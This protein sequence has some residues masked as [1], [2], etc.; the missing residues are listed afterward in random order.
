MVAPEIVTRRRSVWHYG[1]CLLIGML[2]VWLAACSRTTEVPPTATT[3]P[4]AAVAPTA[5]LPPSPTTAPP[6]ET[7]S[8]TPTEA[9]TATAE[10][11]GEAQ[12]TT[13]G[14]LRLGSAVI[15][16]NFARGDQLFVN[17]QNLPPLE[18][19]KVYAGWLL[20]YEGVLS[21]PVGQIPVDAD[22]KAQL[23]FDAPGREN[24]LTNYDG[25][26]LSIEPEEIPEIPRG[27]V[28]A[29]GQVSLNSME[30][31]R[32]LLVSY[33]ETPGEVGLAVGLR[34][35]TGEVLRHTQYARDAARAEDLEG[36]KRHA[37]HVVL[38]I[39]GPNGP[40]YRDLDGDGQILD[41]GDSFG[42]LDAEGQLGY[43]RGVAEKAR[44]AGEA[45][46][47]TELTKIHS[48]HV[49]DAAENTKDWLTRVRDIALTIFADDDL[50]SAGGKVQ[51]MVAL[52]ERA[53]NGF[54]ANN[55][56]TIEPILGE[57]GAKIAYQHSQFLAEMP[58][59]IEDYE[60]PLPAVTVPDTP[61]PTPS[62]SPTATPPPPEEKAATVTMSNFGFGPETITVKAGTTVTFVNQDEAP[63]TATGDGKEFDTG[64]LKP[65]QSTEITF[66]QAG[67]F[68]Y[69]C[70]FHGGPGGQGMAGTIVVEP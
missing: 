53:L 25:F 33:P 15:R 35:Q 1:L 58:L 54:D 49:Q 29:W 7:P 21:L 65:G 12:Q 56:E 2:S 69:F 8:A 37:E 55:N 44:Q 38:L 31:I 41:P 34:E 48:Q 18:P 26:L 4:T 17:L 46:F 43:V 62:P 20:G 47:A 66:R 45:R 50:T 32:H 63:H 14:P 64:I 3:P 40:N 22:G 5:T 9:P 6:T 24:L 23:T 68:P 52:A 57:A 10:P 51:E 67:E 11:T 16:D 70:Q 60:V 59:V 30:H 28:V 42:L 61:T 27:Q 13:G 36:V 19:G 39:E